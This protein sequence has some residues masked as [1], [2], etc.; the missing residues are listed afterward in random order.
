MR[1]RGIALYMKGCAVFLDVHLRDKNMLI[2]TTA[3]ATLC[4]PE[5]QIKRPA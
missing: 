4:P 2:V 1:I 5:E 3:P